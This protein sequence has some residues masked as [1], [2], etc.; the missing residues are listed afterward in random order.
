[1][2]R[3]IYQGFTQ[4]ANGKIITGATV[5]VYLAGTTTPA[6]IYAADSG[7]VAITGGALTSDAD[8]GKFSFY[9]DETSY[10]YNTTKF[11]LVLS[12]TS[13]TTTTLE[14]IT[15]NGLPILSVNYVEYT[16][17]TTLADDGVTF[18]PTT[19][20]GGYAEVMLGDGE[21]FAIFTF[22]SAAAVSLR[23][24][25]TNVAASDSDGNLCIFDGGTAVTIKNRLGSSKQL[26]IHYRYAT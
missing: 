12:K 18:L 26:F 17:K 23:V 10:Y 25:S 13:Y 9:V 19:L 7:G 1:M 24:N 20:S 22:T 11:D 21:E 4:D 6:V 3:F 5:T 15:I 8:T 2:A 16:G 14:D